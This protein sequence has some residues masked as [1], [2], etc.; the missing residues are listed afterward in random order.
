MTALCTFPVLSLS[1]SGMEES[2]SQ[3]Y[4]STSN[5]AAL[6]SERLLPQN[7]DPRE[8]RDSL[9]L[10]RAPKVT[11]FSE[12]LRQSFVESIPA[13]DQRRH[14]SKAEAT[15]SPQTKPR[16][17][18]PSQ[19][20]GRQGPSQ[21]SSVTEATEYPKPRKNRPALTLRQRLRRAKAVRAQSWRPKAKGNSQKL[22]K[23][24]SGLSNVGGRSINSLSKAQDQSPAPSKAED[25]LSYTNSTGTSSSNTD[26]LEPSL[27]LSKRK[28]SKDQSPSPEKTEVSPTSTNYA[29]PGNG[30]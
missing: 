5:T 29:A 22:T 10:S 24:S 7:S 26:S 12:N 2:A 30:Q 1:T 20:P 16:K 3:E 4:K 9:S 17:T 8:H 28:H 23:T 15:Q 19:S 14:S 18:E 21:S 6:S 11:Q 13:H 25:I 27:Q